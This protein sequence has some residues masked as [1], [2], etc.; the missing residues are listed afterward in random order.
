MTNP[1]PRS[2]YEALNQRLFESEYQKARKEKK[3]LCPLL[4]V[5]GR[6]AEERIAYHFNPNRI[7][8]Q[9]TVL[10]LPPSRTPSRPTR[11]A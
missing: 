3:Y 1:T 4:H 9:N 8:E 11:F 2:E 7:H 10:D 5:T 6:A